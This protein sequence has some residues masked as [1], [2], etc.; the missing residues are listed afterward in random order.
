MCFLTQNMFHF[1]S[2]VWYR[3]FV[4]LRHDARMISSA[5]GQRPN[6]CMACPTSEALLDLSF[7]L[8]DVGP[9]ACWVGVGVQP[10]ILVGGL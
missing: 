9:K 8:E 10:E 4:L 5:S 3:F 2:V 1:S 6:C 7:V